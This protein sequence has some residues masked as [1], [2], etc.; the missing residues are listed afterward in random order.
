MYTC[1]EDE[2][3]AKYI[4]RTFGWEI[5]AGIFDTLYSYIP[6]DLQDVNRLREIIIVLDDEVNKE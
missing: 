6:R 4:L 5:N 3:L 1:P 2:F